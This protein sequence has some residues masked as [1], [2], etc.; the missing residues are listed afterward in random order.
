L[1]TSKHQIFSRINE[2]IFYSKSGGICLQRHEPSPPGVAHTVYEFNKHDPSVFRSMAWIKSSEGVWRLLISTVHLGLDSQGIS[3]ASV[4]FDRRRVP[5]ALP[6]LVARCSSKAYGASILKETTPTRSR[7]LG[8][9]V[10]LT[11]GGV[12]RSD[13]DNSG[14][15]FQCSFGSKVCS[16]GGGTSEG[17]SSKR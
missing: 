14:S 17:S 1:Q 5:W 13:F 2:L 9:S 15:G 3:S 11:F 6:W 16:S 10:L 7:W 4:R 8:H 12:V